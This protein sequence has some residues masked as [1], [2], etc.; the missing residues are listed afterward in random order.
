M[1]CTCGADCT[2]SCEGHCAFYCSDGRC[3]EGCYDSC[4][5][6]CKTG[7]NTACNS[8]CSGKTQKANLDKLILNNGP[9]T[10]E[11][12]NNINTAVNFE[13]INRRGLS[14]IVQNIVFKNKEKI[15]DEKI[16][17]I[18]QNLKQTEQNISQSANEKTLASKKFIQDIINT[19]TA[20]NNEVIAVDE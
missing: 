12:M 17:N 2:T 3:D 5:G 13:V 11:F 20:A 16:N 1:D 4:Y 10:A 6:S 18:I 7:C 19:I 8:T 14:P 9:F 15:D